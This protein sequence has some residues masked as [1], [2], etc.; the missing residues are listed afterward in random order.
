MLCDLDMIVEPDAALLPFGEDIGLG[1]QGPQR[2]ALD[3]LEQ[4]PAAGAE[5]PGHPVVQAIDEDADRGV[6]V[7]Q[8][9]EPLVAQP[10]HDPA[11][12]NLDRHLDLGVRRRSRTGGDSSA[13]SR[14]LRGRAG[15]I[16]VP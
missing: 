4:V 3:L 5:M 16:A 15:T 8:R 13:H 6:Q 10:R 7:R 11:L 12:C 14:G 9:E 1:R 2:G